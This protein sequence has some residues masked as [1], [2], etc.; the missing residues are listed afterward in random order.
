MG[1]SD[2]ESDIQQIQ[3]VM[4]LT[5]ADL[6]LNENQ[7]SVLKKGFCQRKPA[8]TL[9]GSAKPAQGEQR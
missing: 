1:F 7:D 2:C 5:K 9:P 6:T 8:K 3:K 4:S